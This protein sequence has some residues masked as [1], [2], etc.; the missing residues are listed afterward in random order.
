MLLFYYYLI[1]VR[2]EARSKCDVNGFQCVSVCLIL[3]SSRA[4]FGIKHVKTRKTTNSSI[5]IIHNDDEETMQS[6]R[7]LFTLQHFSSSSSSSSHL[8][9]HVVETKRN[10]KESLPIDLTD[11][12]DVLYDAN[13]N[14][15][16]GGGGGDTRRQPTSIVKHHPDNSGVTSLAFLHCPNRLARNA[17]NDEEETDDD[18]DDE[19]PIFKCRNR[20][21]N[22]HDNRHGTQHQQSIT[23]A[24][25]INNLKE[26]DSK[27]IDQATALTFSNQTSLL[28]S[29]HVNGQAYIWDLNR[30]K[31]AFSLFDN[32]KE[33]MERG[34]AGSPGLALSRLEH[35]TA[36]SSL[37]TDTI[38]TGLLFQTRDEKGTISFHDISSSIDGCRFVDKIESHSLTFCHATAAS[39]T[40]TSSMFDSYLIATPSKHESVVTLWDR[41]QH[42]ST[43][44][45]GT[46]H[47]AGLDLINNYPS[48]WRR[49]GMVMSLKFGTMNHTLSSSSEST[50]HQSFVLG[51]G[52]ENGSLYMH[53]LR[54]IN[55]RDGV[56]DCV[57]A[58][59][60]SSTNES[61]IQYEDEI[62]S[63]QHSSIDLGINPILSLD[64][65]PST[66]TTKQ[67]NEFIVQDSIAPKKSSIIA[68]AG[69]AGDS[70]EQLDLPEDKRGTVNVI[71]VT[72]ESKASSTNKTTDNSSIKHRINMRLRAK[73]GTCKISEDAPFLGK[74]GVDICRF[75]PDGAYFAVGGWDRRVRIYSRTSAKLMG[76]LKGPNEDSIKCLDW[77][78]GDDGL[79]KAGVLAAGSGDGKIT[80]FRT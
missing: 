69:T 13:D 58:D 52:M 74:S 15:N 59:T 67:S 20:L 49:D 22:P 39:S 56:I 12:D 60:L 18:D 36:S 5:C 42:N 25:T 48:T 37:T 62:K 10:K 14:D 21:L 4:L 54:K 76:I 44:P 73:V 50:S 38:T 27:A 55:S 72:A 71:K 26:K 75:R 79:V 16:G 31:V 35:C 66:A 53:D 61:G 51:C 77:A 47:G 64:M 34:G 11:L 24:S 70:S 2:E 46:I 3:N 41:R 43:R 23:P 7:P 30:R 63:I 29:S 32:H 6:Y 8:H 19:M 68:I 33:Q 45:V 9:H 28:A 65:R 40:S 57:H 1:R 80:I 17:R 78:I